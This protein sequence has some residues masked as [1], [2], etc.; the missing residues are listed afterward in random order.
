MSK[1]TTLD[2]RVSHVRRV[3]ATTSQIVTAN[4]VVYKTSPRGTANRDAALYEP[5]RPDLV[6]SARLTLT[7]GGYVSEIGAGVALKAGEELRTDEEWAESRL[8]TLAPRGTVLTTIVRHVSQSGMQR[9]IQVVGVDGDRVPID[10][11]YYIACIGLWKIHPN[12]PGL[13]V[14]G[15]GMDMAYHVVHTLARRLYGDGYALDHRTI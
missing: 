6:K 9:A 7:A 2:V 12:H 15:A 5:M 13:K 3:T 4:G 11:T 14:N 8:R 10:L 1:H